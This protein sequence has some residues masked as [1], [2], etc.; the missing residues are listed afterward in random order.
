MILRL[1]QRLRL[2]HSWIRLAI[3]LA[4]VL[5]IPLIRLAFAATANFQNGNFA[6]NTQGGSTGKKILTAVDSTDITGWSVYSGSVDL[7]GSAI[8]TS[9]SGSYSVDLDGNAPGGISQLFATVAGQTYSLAFDLSGNPQC[10]GSS[11]S[12]TGGNGETKSVLVNIFD[13]T[14][15]S[16]FSSQT[17]TFSTASNTT[18]N[19]GWITKTVSFT[20]SSGSAKIALASQD[21]A[22]SRCGPVVANFHLY[23]TIGGTVFEDLNYGGGVGRDKA[24]SSGGS[25][26]PNARVELYGS[27]GAF[28][29]ATTTSGTGLYSLQVDAN[30]TYTVRVVNA[31]V[32]SARAGAT[33]SLVP[34]QTFRTSAASGS[35]VEVTDHVGGENPALVDAGSNTSAATLG[36]LTTAS[37]TAQSI[38]TVAV[39]NSA[40][41]GVDFGFNFDTIVNTS[42]SGQGSLVQWLANAAA[43]TDQSTLVQSGSRTIAGVTSSL[44]AGYE[45]SIFMIPGGSAVGGLRA[46]IASQL[47]SGYAAISPSTGSVNLQQAYVILDGATQTANVGNTNSGSTGT[48][49]TVGTSATALATFDMPEV[50]VTLANGSCVCANASYDIVRALGV[51]AGAVSVGGNGDQ[52]SDVLVGMDAQGNA[53][54]ATVES[55]SY[56]ITVGAV[57][58][59]TINHNYVKV[60]NSGVRRDGAGSNLTVQYN[61]IASPYGGQTNTFDGVIVYPGSGDLVQYNLVRNLAGAG[62]EVPFG[63]GTN[64]LV[65]QNTFQANGL[66]YGT[67][68]ASSEPGGVVIYGSASPRPQLTLQG[69]VITGNGG[70]GIEIMTG[71]GFK[72]TQNSIYGNN[73]GTTNGIGIDLD[74]SGQN[75]GNS[76][77]PQGVA[78][79][80]GS[81]N[82]AYPNN[83]INSPVFTYAG[84]TGSTLGVSGYVGTASSHAA[85][86]NVTVEIF[87]ASPNSSGYGDGQ[88]YLGTLTA[89]GNG[90]FSGTL[91]VPGG[92][93][94]VI[95]NVLTATATDTSG[96]TSEFGANFTINSTYSLAPGSFNAFETATASGA[97][98]G[99]IQTKI[100]GSS[101]GLDIVA[102]NTAGTAV[103]TTFTGSVTVQLLDASNNSGALVN[104][105]RSSW[106]AIG[107]AGTVTFAGSNNGR[108]TT[109]FTAAN[110][111]P[112]VRVQMTYTP[113]FGSTVVSCSTD[114]FA[115]RPSTLALLAATDSS[116]STYGTGRSLANAT[117][118]GG[119][120]H[121]AGQP[122][123]LSAQAQNAAGVLTSNYSGTTTA[124]LGCLLPA[125]CGAANLGSLTFTPT[126][127]GG[128]MATNDAAYSDV[129]AFT[130]QLVDTTFAAVDAADSTPAQRYIYSAVVNVGRFVPD[131]FAL[132]VASAGTQ[133]TY[134]SG[135]C[136]TRSFTYLGQPVAYKSVPVVGVTAQNASNGTTANY[137][138]ELWK[139]TS[140]SVAQ[141]YTDSGGYALSAAIGSATV[142]SAGNGTG[143]LSPNAADTVTWTR[144]ST[145]P[146]APFAAQAVDTF[147]VAD[148]S[149]S[150]GSITQAATAAASP[151]FDDGA[152]MV[153]GRI[154]LTNAY[155]VE[156]QS[157]AVP[158]ET[159]YYT[160]SVWVTNAGD[161]CTAIP[162]AALAFANWQKSLNACETSVSGGGT[163]SRGRTSLL[164]S[165][166]GPGNTGSVDLTL[167][168]GA[169]ASGSACIAGAAQSSTT[170]G[171]GFLQGAWGGATY[172]VNP[173]GRASFGEYGVMPGF[174]R[175]N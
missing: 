133:Y 140:A 15:G 96:D 122:F 30:A 76:F 142:T 69:N 130:L 137:K 150:S 165:A 139:L 121:K 75:N 51:Y 109:N 168:L 95:G 71:A 8:W 4:L 16:V 144:S 58:N 42:G 55:S 33:S 174:R 97:I 102:I 45:T 65:Q 125:G 108:L 171:L 29:G 87:K 25:A 77:S 21:L 148:T 136:A 19:M 53:T 57:S 90:N 48:G 61:E 110:A 151:A 50:Q 162:G 173:T 49:G 101:F 94:L 105:C 145:T 124:I 63:G 72:I 131:H 10:N 13:G 93:S 100:A 59:V 167:N 118:T 134:G 159:Q 166:P 36:S 161:F 160:G 92:V 40:I 22:S 123:T 88:T 157:L 32:T 28:V 103:D 104:T 44:P 78:L 163:V 129:G 114:N 170:T 156:T 126:L 43:F 113:P 141:T 18:S 82:T 107:S 128:V 17:Y 41:G 147:G 37:A 20:A 81:F 84:V 24:A 56:G 116:W 7:V 23:T 112:N 73:V 91:T 86:A 153:F 169:T 38:T 143:T 158:A 127:S 66:N 47:T 152:T 80:T 27:T 132:A 35:V 64:L 68:T 12:G 155:G 6:S 83:G 89:D 175:E 2:P 39:G 85:F 9:S 34:V 106:V 1:G 26:R 154:A 138:N 11:S 54:A 99:V 117:A 79:N 164:L 67:S 146:S 14:S 3:V 60:N 52:V 70:D 172:S 135:G 74:H 31:T 120:V 5:S 98:T 115:I 149:E 46:G 62:F 119:V 111:Y